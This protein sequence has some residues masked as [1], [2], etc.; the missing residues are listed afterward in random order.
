MIR[1]VV[2][3]LALLLV[4]NS[5]G[6]VVIG[7]EASSDGARDRVLAVAKSTIGQTEK[8]GRND[9]A[10]VDSVLASVGL[11]G[12]GA[13]WCAAWNRYCYDKAGFRMVGPRS[14]LASKWVSDPTWTIAR[15]GATPKPGDPWGI[16]FPSKKRIA[17]TGLV[18]VWGTKTVRTIEGNTSPDAVAGSAADRD[19]GGVYSKIRLIRQIHSAKNW[20]D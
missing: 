16:Y 13:P 4:G 10:F 3:S 9:G 14:A 17:H 6:Q 20:L 19:G 2:L 12:T 8:T 1:Y 15:G 5:H 18:W 11:E 7:V